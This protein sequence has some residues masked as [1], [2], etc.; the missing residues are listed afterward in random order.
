MPTVALPDASG[1]YK[2]RMHP[3]STVR[4]DDATPQPW[5]NGGGTTRELLAW[6][7]SADWRVRVSVAEIACDAPFSAFPG[8]ERWLAV[9]EGAGVELRIDDVAYRQGGAAPPLRF[10]GDAATRCRLL[11]GPTLDLNLMLRGTRGRMLACTD[12]GPWPAGASRGGLFARGAGLCRSDAF[13]D[14][15]S[16]PARSLLWFDPAPQRLRF[17]ADGATR[18]DGACGWWLQCMA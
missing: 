15:L 7:S 4:T 13:D 17:T 12:D 6:P 2:R 3:T 9:L 18:A 10:A 16:V 11:D 14:A 5:R 8:V 1:W